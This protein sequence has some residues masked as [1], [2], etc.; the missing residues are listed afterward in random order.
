MLTT[1]FLPDNCQYCQDTILTLNEPRASLHPT[2]WF[3]LDSGEYLSGH[4]H[5]RWVQQKLDS[6]LLR[7]SM[8]N[9]C[10]W[11][12]NLN[13][14]ATYNSLDCFKS[15]TAL[16]PNAALLLWGHTEFLL[17]KEETWAKI[18]RPT[19]GTQ[20]SRDGAAKGLFHDTSLDPRLST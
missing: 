1:T 12:Q 5:C 2:W 17:F 4:S 6:M 13:I 7:N 16:I 20:V 18:S 14:N 3:L 10:M 19:R 9:S 8:W 15:E 11:R